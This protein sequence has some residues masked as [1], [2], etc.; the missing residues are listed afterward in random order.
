MCVCVLVHKL[1]TNAQA[2]ELVVLC[3]ALEL[4]IRST[5]ITHTPVV[6]AGQWAASSD[7]P[8]DAEHVLHLGKPLRQFVLKRRCLA[9][10][11]STLVVRLGARRCQPTCFP[12]ARMRPRA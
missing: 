5:T 10:R 4:G 9:S 6:A 11:T 1:A 7:G 8:D 2:G 12:R 3:I